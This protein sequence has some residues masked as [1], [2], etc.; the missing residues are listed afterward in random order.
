MCPDVH[1]LGEIVSKLWSVE[2]AGR[3]LINTIE[4]RRDVNLCP[5]THAPATIAAPSAS[6]DMSTFGA[7]TQSMAKRFSRRKYMCLNASFRLSSMSHMTGA[8]IHVVSLT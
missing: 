3:L 7:E 6:S 8:Y 2:F 5:S 1:M 4:F